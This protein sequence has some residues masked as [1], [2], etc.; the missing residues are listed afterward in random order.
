VAEQEQSK[1]LAV[2][3]PTYN[4]AEPLRRSL[5]AMIPQARAY[6]IPIYIR[7][8]A[9]TD[10]TTKVVVAFQKQYP[11][12]Y[13]GVN[14]TNLGVDENMIKAAQ[15]ASTKYVWVI[16]A[17]RIIL[18]GMMDKIYVYLAEASLDLL[19]LNDLNN[20]F[21]VPPSQCY[22]SPQKLFRELNRNLTGLGFQILP[23]EAWKLDVDK[24]AGTEWTIVGLSLEYIAKKPSIEAYF[25]A[26]P[27]ATSSG[28]S[29]WRPKFFQIWQNWKKTI[30]MLPP[31]YPSEDKELVIRKSVRFLYVSSLFTLFEL[32]VEGIFNA[33]TF[34]EYGGDLQKYSGV[35]P[36]TAY[37]IARLPTLPLKFYFRAY[38]GLRSLVRKLIHQQSPLNPTRKTNVPYL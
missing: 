23:A 19:V 22:T 2:C 18:P 28:P 33:K 20:T 1:L 38:A 31:V 35:A 17:R 7:D 36:T 37:V 13:Y 6:G 30:R 29:H 11:F 9:S 3:I 24:Y 14:S 32:R 12:L 15:M 34:R 27:I 5:E 8:N 4:H 10:H 16:G 26:E 21:V 25:I